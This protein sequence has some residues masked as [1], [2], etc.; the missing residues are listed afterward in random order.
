ML[1]VVKRVLIGNPIATSEEHHQRL[2]KRV[3]LP[4][5]ASDA[6]SSTAYA[7]DEIMVVLGVQAGIGAAA[8]GILTPIAIVVAILLVIVVLSYRQTI[9]AYPSGGGSYVVSRENLGVIPSL[10]AGASLLT[11]Y[12]LTV[13][14]SVAGGVLAIQ[15]A[16]GFDSKWR[17]PICLVMVAVMTIANLRG[18][19]E[20][21]ALF[22]PPTYIYIVMLVLLIT[23][24]LFR[25]YF[26][27]LGPIPLDQL[28]DEAREL[29]EGGKALGILMLLRAF[30]SGAVALSGVEAVSNGVPAFRRPESRNAAMTIAIMGGILG[31]C[32][33]G[34]SVLA[35]K[36]QP[37]RGENDPTGIALMAEHIYGGKGLLFW[38]TQIATFA[39][40]ILAANTA[41]ADFPRL[42]SII[43]RDGHLPRQL[44]NRGDRL[45][46]SNGV[47][48]LALL[49]S[50]LIII[51]KG[52]ISALIP[53]YAF[54][55]FTGFTLSQ[56][57]MVV[58]HFRLREP[59]WRASAVINAVGCV[60]TGVV[61]L[62]VVV[63]KFT[64]GAWIPAVVIPVFVVGFRSIGKHYDKV[65]AAVR[66]KEG[67]R[68][69]R[70][71][72]LVVVL[73]GSVNQG[74]IDAVDYARS[75][76]PERLIAVSVVTDNAEMEQLSAEWTAR[77]MSIPLHTISSP[78]RE[79][80]RPVLDYLDELDAENPDE[81]LTVVI[82]EFVTKWSSQWLHNQSALALKARLL[83]RPNT[84]VTSIP[85]LVEPPRQNP[86]HEP[87]TTLGPRER[88]SSAAR[89]AVL[90][91]PASRR[92]ETTV[93]LCRL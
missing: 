92:P 93:G 84:V 29:A 37:W 9:Y 40:L 7:T 35:S 31:T 71:Q 88:H 3:A 44:A 60:A 34:V 12:I 70:R 52:N 74:V 89:R 32:F 33:L 82:P 5:F 80:T 13:A 73:V 50:V 6:I 72:H 83:Y 20:S 17:V 41:Y 68:R 8:W 59:R 4:V 15:S 27:D 87:I 30:S 45:V 56:A 10:V 48:A 14:V 46:F 75:L 90:S 16:F 42:S 24:G 57:G 79:L 11:D 49:A 22:A 53:L 77:E 65:R 2:G 63:S 66:A 67:H 21:G 19:R 85:V 54:G 86:F 91:T 26:Q 28:S 61:A 1:P 55:V 64:E 25:I 58:H 81:Q 38:V 62:V 76:A 51:F 18:V 43:A 78:Y 47:I 36:L 69:R 39:I 23:V